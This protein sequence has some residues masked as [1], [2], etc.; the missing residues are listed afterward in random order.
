MGVSEQQYLGVLDP[1]LHND[2]D[3]GVLFNGLQSW[4]HPYLCGGIFTWW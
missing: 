1:S 3:L 2:L 4:T